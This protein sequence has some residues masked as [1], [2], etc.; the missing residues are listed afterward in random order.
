[1][2]CKR[3]IYSFSIIFVLVQVLISGAKGELV[4]WWRLDEGVGTTV[5]DSSGYGRDGTFQGDPEWI[6]GKTGSALEFD[7]NDHVEVPDGAD[8]NPESITM[9]TWVSFNDV[10]GRQDFIS[11]SDD[12]AF[13]LGGN[14]S[15]GKIWAVITTDGDWLD[16]GGRS[17]IEVGRWY[18]V[19]LTYD[20]ETQLLTLYLDGEQDG[21][22]SAPA[23]LEH[24]I[25]GPLTIGTYQARNLD[26]K[27]D[28]I[29]IWDEAL[30]V[31]EIQFA[32]LGEGYPYAFAP[33]PADGAL[34]QDTWVTLTWSAGDMAVSHDVYMGVNFDDVNEGAGGTFRGNQMDTFYVAGFPG[35]AY[36]EGLLPGTTYY[37]RIDEVNDADPN[38][39]W[40]GS[41]WSFMVPPRT[42]Y[43][44]DPA[45]GAE[46]VDPN[47]P[48]LS[49]TPGFSAKLHTV[50][51]G[52]NFD[53]VN[54][55]T[56]GAPRGL[57]TY[58]TDTLE[59]EKVYYWRVD[60]FD[61]VTTYK[62]DVWTFTTPGAVGNPQPAYQAAD[63]QLNAILSWTPADSTASH[64]LYFGT[65]K[66]AVRSADTGSPEYQ[67]SIALEA[68][69]YDPGLLE[70]DTTYY[71]RVDEVDA[72]GNTVKGPLWMF[73][74]GTFILIDDFENYT[75]DDAA[76]LAIWQTWIDGYGVA[77]NGAQ[78][79]YLVPPYAESGSE[80]IHDGS[81][82]MPLSF[83]NEAN[84][85]NS[86]AAMTLS[87]PR[88]WTQ[89]NVATLSVWFRGRSTNA[90]EPLY[91]S[92][93][94]TTGAPVIVAY[95]DQNAAQR[96]TWTKWNV[97]LQ[98]FADQGINLAD[99]DSLAIGLGSTSGIASSGGSGTMY[100]DDIRLERP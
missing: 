30:P 81:Q 36:P 60:E 14:P 5:Y 21:Q 16:V 64:Q 10:S 70:P 15:D 44:P 73:T 54:N 39:P 43:Y 90:A 97:P 11:R 87:A 99:V 95:E 100:F 58:Q 45:D 89:A 62:G 61:A 46:N 92:I 35:F 20:T 34:H 69:Q 96:I 31:E 84:V 88:D 75:D 49:W 41:V 8:I 22:D 68:E 6:A 85:T 82:S 24:R 67:G 23:G 83:A 18:H 56:G 63:I 3:M 19:A 26:G 33:N 72:Q 55:A 50:Y 86:E 98:T 29:K 94:N 13:S 7:G 71:W 28:E 2:M 59:R 52:D 38:S 77:D 78:V 12:Y 27:L 93:S 91:L 79:G 66:N 48:I 42:A 4:G 80:R 40:K 1:M 47:S 17:P 65:D 57:T 76:G 37:W 74:T 25:G 53:E 9:A 51:F 32:M